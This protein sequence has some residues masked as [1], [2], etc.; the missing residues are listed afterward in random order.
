M[1]LKQ[2]KTSQHHNWPRYMYCPQ[3]GRKSAKKTGEKNAKR[4][5][6]THFA[7]PL[8]HPPSPQAII[9][10][11]S[12]KL[13]LCPLEEVEASRAG[14]RGCNVLC[15]SPTPK[16]HDTSLP[17]SSWPNISVKSPPPWSCHRDFLRFGRKISAKIGQ[18]QRISAWN[19]LVDQL[20][21]RKTQKSR[22]K[23]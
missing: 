2:G 1:P 15:I 13:L 7:R 5:N 16:L 12:A 23:K 14:L 9:P 4:T 3:I 6:G 18:S 11:L 10:P 21:N 8:I 19:Q 17:H 22:E 20:Q